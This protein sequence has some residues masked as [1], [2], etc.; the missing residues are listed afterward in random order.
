MSDVENCV[1][2]L[3]FVGLLGFYILM[4]TGHEKKRTGPTTVSSRRLYVSGKKRPVLQVTDATALR[5]SPIS[6]SGP[7]TGQTRT[8]YTWSHDRP[9]VSTW[10]EA[11]WPLVYVDREKGLK[12]KGKLR[13]AVSIAPGPRRSPGMLL[14]NGFPVYQYV[15]DTNSRVVRGEGI[16]PSETNI[17]PGLW[18]AVRDQAGPLV[19]PDPAGTIARPGLLTNQCSS[20][21]V[22]LCAASKGVPT[23][24]L[25]CVIDGK[26]TLADYSK[27]SHPC[28]KGSP[29]GFVAPLCPDRK[30]CG[31]N[32]MGCVPK[33]ARKSCT[34]YGD[35]GRECPANASTC[36][37]VQDRFNNRLGKN[38]RHAHSVRHQRRAKKLASS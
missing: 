18:Q 8:L 7:A 1:L 17:P 26:C 24:S 31:K 5:E 36:R 13:A 21:D 32:G 33:N 19:K 27:P 11:N 23:D 37:C 3:V 25:V 12:V 29:C 14:I 28:A 9:G 30:C 10:K 2:I 34:P 20:S 16:A 38:H 6:K 15:V 35:D 4:W 22:T